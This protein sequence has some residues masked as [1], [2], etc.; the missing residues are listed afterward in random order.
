[1]NC[2]RIRSGGNWSY[3]LPIICRSEMQKEK[4]ISPQTAL[5]AIGYCQ[6]HVLF[7]CQVNWNNS[8][9]G[10][11]Q[12]GIS[13]GTDSTG[14]WFCCRISSWN[15]QTLHWDKKGCRYALW[16][17]CMSSQCSMHE[18]LLWPSSR[19]SHASKLLWVSL[20]CCLWINYTW[21]DRKEK[22]WILRPHGTDGMVE[23]VREQKKEKIWAFRSVYLLWAMMLMSQSLASPVSFPFAGVL[24][25]CNLSFSI[26][27]KPYHITLGS[28]VCIISFSQHGLLQLKVAAF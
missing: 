22:T 19:I 5:L 24:A 23:S 11:L 18:I 1:M 20:C 13:W 6:R 26:F 10:P 17:L 3:S 12:S 16:L 15:K 21:V 27:L 2:L 28:S 8:L 7:P 9:T 4:E 14:N 25:I